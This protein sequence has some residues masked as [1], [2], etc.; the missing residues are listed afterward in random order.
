M[1]RR[2]NKPTDPAEIARLQR[3]RKGY[4]RANDR[5][6]AKDPERWGLADDHLAL[7]A[8]SDVT[9]ELANR[10]KQ[11]HT[12]AARYDVFALLNSRKALPK[13]E[14]Q[15]I[16]RYERDLAIR[17]ME[18]GRASAL[19]KVDGA[20]DGTAPVDRAVD[21]GSRIDAVLKQMAHR[22][23]QLLV[24]VCDPDRPHQKGKHWRQTVEHVTGEHR[25]TFQ[26]AIIRLMCVNAREAYEAHD[27]S[28]A[29]KK[30]ATVRAA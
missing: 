30:R 9:V 8:N 29:N 14:E 27:V 16:R 6:V 17:R 22:H 13:Q 23:A 21:A 12:R 4:E 10:D 15:A 20:S 26:A 3:I 7:A 2:R 1:A 25:P 11:A 5:E 19:G 28:E 18:T 24:A